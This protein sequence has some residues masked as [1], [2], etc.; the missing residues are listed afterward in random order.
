MTSFD[1]HR[2]NVLNR[3]SLQE[4]SYRENPYKKKIPVAKKIH[5]N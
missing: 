2:F 4:N 1:D 3:K 5:K